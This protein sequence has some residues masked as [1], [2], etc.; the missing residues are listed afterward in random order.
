MTCDSDCSELFRREFRFEYQVV[1]EVL[2]VRDLAEC[3]EACV[4]IGKFTC[5]GFSFK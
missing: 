5:R 2:A 4:N 1:R 3:E